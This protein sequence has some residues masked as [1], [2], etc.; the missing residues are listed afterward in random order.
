MR[1]FPSVDPGKQRLNEKLRRGRGAARDPR[2]AAL[3]SPALARPAG[4]RGCVFALE[5]VVIGFAENTR[6]DK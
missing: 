4:R 5:R 3:A 6:G 1:P 2:A